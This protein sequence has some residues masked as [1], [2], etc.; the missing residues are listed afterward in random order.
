MEPT[1]TGAR[2]CA[3]TAT[4]ELTRLSLEAD[5][6]C[7][8]CIVGAG[9]A[10]LSTAYC[11]AKEGKR[12]V[13]IDKS[14]I[15]GGETGHTT[16]H[17]SNAIDDRYYEIR[18][19]HGREGARTCADSHT[20]AIE[21]IEN[22]VRQEGIDCAFERLDGYLFVPPGASR[23]VLD[24]E[25]D[26]AIEAGVPDVELVARAPLDGFDTG[27]CLRFGQQAQMHP[28]SY[29]AGL[30]AAIERLNGRIFCHTEMRKLSD[31]GLSLT[32]AGGHRI[33]A[34]AIVVATNTPAINRVVIHTKQ[35]AYRTYVIGIRVS[36]GKVHRALYWDTKQRS[37]DSADA[38]YHYVRLAS[39]LHDPSKK[40]DTETLI[41]G[42]EDH[43]TGQAE[44]SEERWARLL[45]WARERFADLGPVEYRWSGQI[46]EPVDHVAFIGP[47]PTGP[48]NVYIATGDSGMGMTH[49]AIAGLL[50]TDLITG[51]HNPWADLYDP[52]RVT[53]SSAWDY[54][55]ENL[56][57]AVQYA[58]RVR[59][60]DVTSVEQI[61]LGEG[62]VIRRGLSLVA[63]HRDESGG[64]HE[65]SAICPHLGC[66][67][68]WNS[69]EKTWDCPC[70]GSRFDTKGMVL[71][72][73]A[74][75]PLP[76]CHRPATAARV[77]VG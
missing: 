39:D 69:S 58:G 28:I 49:G 75:T 9:M 50:L 48:G 16:C 57:V 1:L 14:H 65:R 17:L 3:W 46:M 30:A 61:P 21:H 63:V 52:S 33:D 27:P 72:G 2:P 23:D 38:P 44:H 59:P 34:S 62:A 29:L 32:T 31:D 41:V 73:P 76:P 43:K 71:N 55:R 54:A 66:V 18:R 13:V 56:N 45:E 47:N 5:T 42:G 7:D 8:V 24:R 20:A 26:A 67:V 70:H 15:G 51:R 37:T 6:D 10:G 25:L 19:M 22:V 12:V 40:G 64:L 36:A 74:I 68:A 11:L 4:A 77:P 60:G 53:L 35:A